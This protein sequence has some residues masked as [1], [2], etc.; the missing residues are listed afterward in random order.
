MRI[1]ISLIALSFLLTSCGKR[2]DYQ[3]Y[4]DLGEDWNFLAQSIPDD[5][6]PATEA[7]G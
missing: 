2:N 1:L 3:K 4:I 5:S 6:P 7:N